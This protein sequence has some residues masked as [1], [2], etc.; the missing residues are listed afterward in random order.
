MGK[1][2]YCAG[3]GDFPEEQWQLTELATVLGCGGYEAYLPFRDG[4]DCLFGSSAA[5]GMNAADRSRLARAIAAFNLYQLM[6]RCAAVV[7]C[8]NGR[9]PDEGGLIAAAVAYMSG[10][11][12]V[13]YKRDH[14]S[15]FYGRDNAM[16]TGLARNFAAVTR[17]EGLYRVV[18][19]EIARARKAERATC[20]PPALEAAVSRGRKLAA[21]AADRQWP[22]GCEADTLVGS[23]LAATENG[24]GTD[25]C[26]PV[27]QLEETTASRPGVWYCSGPLFCPGEVRAMGEI[28][29]ELEAA[30]WETY[31]P[32]RDGVEA[33]VM[34][35]TNSY[36]ANLLPPLA[37]WGHRLTFAVDLYWILRCHGLVF[38]GNGR[39]PDEGGV[40]EIGL[41]FAAG[42]PVL[43]NHQPRQGGPAGDFHPMI[44]G[45]AALSEPAAHPEQIPF[46]AQQY[47]PAG[48]W[49][50][51]RTA[52]PDGLPEPVRDR[53]RLGRRAWNMM[54]RLAFFKPSRLF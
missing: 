39:V 16:I 15:V 48:Y 45:L 24:E 47:D 28:A 31:L 26:T 38:N 36:L 12:V 5:A 33:F 50:D 40:V 13:L 49:T 35:R 25:S 41:A 23:I 34:K 21:M 2:I 1:I 30:G 17:P 42:K 3:A 6:R 11:P 43:L 27:L 20:L 18:D 14:R 7:L 52:R 9:V 22:A 53:A 19:R 8:L 29:E 4:L 51:D 44:T 32:H 54:E 37:A 10:I 46:L